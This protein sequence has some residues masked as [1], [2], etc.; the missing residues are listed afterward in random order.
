VIRQISPELSIVDQYAPV[1]SCE[2]VA[3]VACTLPDFVH[4]T[5]Q[6]NLAGILWNHR[7]VRFG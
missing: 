2:R 4:P 3:D 6:L 5:S 1:A 7:A